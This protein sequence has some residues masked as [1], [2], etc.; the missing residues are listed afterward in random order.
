MV[1]PANPATAPT[2]LVLG[3]GGARAAYQV[4]VLQ[5]LVGIRRLGGPARRSPFDG[6]CGTSTGAIN[7]CALACHNQ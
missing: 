4:G 5:A 3:G 7:A 6:L 2:G 1:N